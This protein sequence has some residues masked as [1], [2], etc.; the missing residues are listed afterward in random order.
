MVLDTEPA[1]VALLPLALLQVACWSSSSC[2][3]L[4][5]LKKVV[6]P[7][8]CQSETKSQAAQQ[9]QSPSTRQEK[10][11]IKHTNRLCDRGSPPTPCMVANIASQVAKKQPGKNWTS[12]FVKSWSAELDS[13]Y[14]NTLD[15]SGHKVESAGPFRQCSDVL[16]SKIEQYGIQPKNMYNMDEKGFLIGYLTKSKRVFT[17]ALFQ[18]RK[19]LGTAQDGNRKWVT[20]VATICA[21]GTSLSPGLIYQG[22]PNTIQDT[23]LEGV[24][25][26][27]HLAFL[28]SS[29]NGWSNDGFGFDWLVNLF[30]RETR[31]KVK[32]DWRLTLL[33]LDGR[34]PHL[35]IQ[36]LDWCQPNKILVAVHPPRSTHRLQPLDVSLFAPLATF[37]SQSLDEHMRLSEGLTG[38]IKRGF[39]GLFWS[40]WQRA[41]TEDNI[42]S[43]WSK[44]GLCSFD[45]SVVMKYSRR[46]QSHPM[47]GLRS[48]IPPSADAAALKAPIWLQRTGGRF[49]A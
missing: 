37:Y 31:F 9:K 21:D 34:G 6:L 22:Q 28:T 29:V 44:T 10:K 49:K 26:E 14:L 45:L 13:K 43:G 35:T 19:L 32:R 16:S 40:A 8:S 20:V 11:L 46:L 2:S 38:V 41:F 33:F 18:S 23:W 5:G 1:V 3:T 47:T 4:R 24:N 7:T 48:H 36:F 42:N 27:E 39:L 12:R 30:D 17:K 25:E 15:I